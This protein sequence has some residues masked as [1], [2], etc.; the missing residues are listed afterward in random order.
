MA[1]IVQTRSTADSTATIN[2]DLATICRRFDQSTDSW[3]WAGA[4]VICASTY[5]V[6]LR[7][8]RAEARRREDGIR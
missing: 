1:A 8:S 4:A 3:T 6:G 2:N 5:Y 7:E